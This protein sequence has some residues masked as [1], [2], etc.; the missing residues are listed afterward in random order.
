M[1]LVRV[2]GYGVIDLT[3]L[4]DLSRYQGQA[5]MKKIR[6]KVA[7]KQTANLIDC[8]LSSNLQ[9]DLLHEGLALVSAEVSKTYINACLTITWHSYIAQQRVR[10]MSLKTT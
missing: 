5:L 6:L 4:K 7:G 10:C 2:H 1:D 8:A 9:P 3:P